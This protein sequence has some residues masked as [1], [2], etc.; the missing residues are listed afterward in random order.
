MNIKQLAVYQTRLSSTMMDSIFCLSKMFLKKKKSQML[1]FF[2]T[3]TLNFQTYIQEE[4]RQ[5]I[6][7]KKN[8]QDQSLDKHHTLECRRARRILRGPIGA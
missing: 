4:E 3:F 2:R 8:R 7:A 1:T 5:N 6:G